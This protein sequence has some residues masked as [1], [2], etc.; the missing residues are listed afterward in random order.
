MQSANTLTHGLIWYLLSY[1]LTAVAKRLAPYLVGDATVA[2][3]DRKGDIIF[4]TDGHPPYTIFA[5]DREYRIKWKKENLDGR[6][7]DYSMIKETLLCYI[8]GRNEPHRLI[9]LDARTG[10]ILYSLSKTEL[11]PIGNPMVVTNLTGSSV[12]YHPN[13]HHKFWIADPKN[14]TVYCTDWNGKIYY[15]IGKYGKSGEINGLLKYPVSVSPGAI[16][17]NKILVS[18][19]AN[20]RVLRY[21]LSQGKIES[22]LPFPY[23]FANY[24]NTSSVAVF[25]SACPTHNHYGAF[26]LSDGLEPIPR[27]HIPMNTNLVIPH[28]KIAYR[29]LLGWDTSLYE[30]DYRNIIYRKNYPG[31]PIE[32]CLFSREK[33]K[34]R[35]SLYSPPVVDWFRTNKSVIIKANQ[36]GKFD[37][38]AANFT[39]YESMW[40]GSWERIDSI[41]IEENKARF[42][43]LN[44]P[45]GIFRVKVTLNQHGM[46]SGWVNLSSL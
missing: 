16:W 15:Q 41:K 31:P 39:G 46:V 25:N 32:N 2:E 36:S 6:G 28:P 35:L 38:E 44:V 9:E 24:I 11:G 29:F 4:V 10:K 21:N 12:H 26:L 27:L 22:Q 5:I 23:P 40:D 18:D 14:H 19:W 42:Y 33:G 3:Y 1:N 20:H 17:G 37:I 8:M 45:L 13:N 30:I 7:L 34:A 43:A